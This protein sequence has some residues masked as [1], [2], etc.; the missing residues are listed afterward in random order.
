MALAL[1]PVRCFVCVILDGFFRITSQVCWALACIWDILDIIMFPHQGSAAKARGLDWRAVWYAFR[2]KGGL[3]G[4]V[5]HQGS[6]I[7]GI[8]QYW[9][10]FHFKRL[11]NGHS[12]NIVPRPVIP[13][14]FL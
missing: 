14:I 2:L 10:A 11:S 4:D 8:W 5:V 6:S 1:S 3:P 12:K 7:S 13:S 9:E